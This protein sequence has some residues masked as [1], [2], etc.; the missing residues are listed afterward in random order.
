MED[1]PPLFNIEKKITRKQELLVQVTR[2]ARDNKGARITTQLSLAGRYLVF[3]PLCP[4]SGVSRKIEDASERE[5]LKA[6][7]D[8]LRPRE[9]GLIARTMS[10]GATLQELKKDKDYLLEMWKRAYSNSVSAKAPVLVHQEVGLLSRI[11]REVIRDDISEVVVDSREGYEHLKKMMPNGISVKLYKDKKP[12]YEYYNIQASLDGLLERNVALPS[13][14]YIVIDQVEALTVIDVN[15]GKF[16]GDND[17]EDTVLKTNMEAAHEITNQLK[18][19]D[20][21]G[22]I[23]VD[24][25]DMLEKKNRE[26]ISEHMNNLLRED[27]SRASVVDITPLGLMEITRKRTRESIKQL[28]TESCP[29]CDGRGHIKARYSICS[30]ILTQLRRLAAKNC[31]K[32]ISIEAHNELTDILLTTGL[33]V[34]SQL[35]AEFKVIVKIEPRGNYHLEKYKISVDGLIR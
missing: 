35:E 5:R 11:Y 7:I 23:I 19:R 18:L 4:H 14:G 26:T 30:E 28:M 29:Y 31:G 6:C 16:V 17:F 9:H 2:D 13:G 21:G 33:S 20:I 22:I 15:T 1:N 32:S 3:L 25:I 10:L 24:F 34:L 12:I 8:E 27:N